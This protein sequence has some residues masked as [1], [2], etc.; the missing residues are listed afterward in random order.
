VFS[1]PE[2]GIGRLILPRTAAD[3]QHLGK[4]GQQQGGQALRDPGEHPRIREI[5]MHMCPLARLGA[6]TKEEL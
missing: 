4:I 6:M 3:I 5:N 2:G 1:V